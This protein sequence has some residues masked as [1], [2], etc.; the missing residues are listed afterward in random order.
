MGFSPLAKLPPGRWGI[1]KVLEAIEVLREAEALLEELKIASAGALRPE[2]FSQGAL[3]V[4]GTHP[5]YLAEF[6][7]QE[8]VFLQTLNARLRTRTRVRRILY[9]LGASATRRAPAPPS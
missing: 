6:Q 5:A 2:R 1:G 4:T 7:L 9:R 8:A 3:T